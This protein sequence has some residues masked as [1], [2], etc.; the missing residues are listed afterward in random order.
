MSQL[1]VK[2]DQG[3]G[4]DLSYDWPVPVDVI[5]SNDSKL[6]PVDDGVEGVG[7]DHGTFQDLT[8]TGGVRVGQGIERYWNPIT[9]PLLSLDVPEPV[10]YSHQDYMTTLGYG[11]PGWVSVLPMG[12]QDDVEAKL[13]QA[14]EG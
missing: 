1:L 4:I 12:P 3:D 14:F 5:Y 2:A 9:M 10:A 6:Y 8:E 7:P 11:D 13:L